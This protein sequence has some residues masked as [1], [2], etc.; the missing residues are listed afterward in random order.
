MLLI[1]ESVGWRQRT[2]PRN[3]SDRPTFAKAISHRTIGD[4]RGEEVR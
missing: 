1:A 3:F 4:R 2:P